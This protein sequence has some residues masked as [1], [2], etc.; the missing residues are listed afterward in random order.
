M[1]ARMTADER[2]V[3][4]A[5]GP[6]MDSRWSEWSRRSRTW[7]RKHR[8]GSWSSCCGSMNFRVRGPR[9]SRWRLLAEHRFLHRPLT[10]G[11]R[12]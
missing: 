1:P 4:Q 6:T 9:M 7:P 11:E 3:S 8:I 5:Q 10:A 12:R 2:V